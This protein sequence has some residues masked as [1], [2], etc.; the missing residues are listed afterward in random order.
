MYMVFMKIHGGHVIAALTAYKCGITT[1]LVYNCAE[2]YTW[3]KGWPAAMHQT[4]PQ[5]CTKILKF[6]VLYG[7]VLYGIVF[8]IGRRFSCSFRLAAQ[9]KNNL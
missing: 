3:D 1:L 2:I 6:S 9:D 5:I 4:L 7:M 8:R